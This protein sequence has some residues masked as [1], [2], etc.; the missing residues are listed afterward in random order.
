MV[1]VDELSNF[2]NARSKRFKSLRRVM[3]LTNR[4]IG[5]TGTPAPNG[6]I[7][8]WPQIYLMDKGERL[9]KTATMFKDRYFT[10]GWR[11]GNI[12]YKWN[13]KPG[14]EEAIYTAIGD[15]LYEYDRWRLAVST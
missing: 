2:K 5:L 3:P 15:I 13:L 4:F 6:L 14:G 12:V 10:P 7:D 9:G 8:L 11:N 1:I